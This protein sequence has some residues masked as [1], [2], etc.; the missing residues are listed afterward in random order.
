MPPQHQPPFTQREP[1]KKLIP[2]FIAGLQDFAYGE[3][4]WTIFKYWAPELISALIFYAFAIIDSYW[5]ADLKSTSTYTTLNVTNNFFHFMSKVAEGLSIGTVI[6]TGQYNGRSCLTDVGRTL[7]DSFWTTILVGG[8]FAAALSFGAHAIY[9]AYG[10]PQR[11]IEIGTP[12]LRLRAWG[13][14]FMFVSLAFIGFLRG[15]KNTRVP[16]WI[17]TGGGAFFV[18]FD[19]VLIKGKFGFPALG[20]KG[21]AIAS[22]AQYVAMS[23]MALGYTFLNKENKKYGIRLFDSFT[24][25]EDVKRLFMVSWP[26]ILDKATVAAAYIWLGAMVAKMGTLALASFSVIKDLERFAFLPAIAFAQVITFL[27]SN[28]YG[29]QDWRGIKS[30]IKKILFLSSGM[31]F[32]I[33]ALFS[34]YTDKLVP[35]FDRKGEFT[36][37]SARVFPYLSVLVFFDLLQL[38]LSGALRGAANVRVV[39]WT[40][41]FVCVLYFAP[42][43]YLFTQLPLD[44]RPALKF[45]L[46]YGSFYLGN[47]L[48]SIVYIRRFRGEAWKKEAVWQK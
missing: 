37:F 7:R 21:S 2:S 10:V 14:F 44:D 15:I 41:L 40:R 4:Y 30:S 22:V 5:I 13:I 18:L 29:M 31:T 6:I 8:I 48:M 33:L 9:T 23:I 1:Q 32:A 42:V 25:W 47:A 46:V 34:I 12:Y 45:F 26:T 39:M 28:S 20:L 16:M 3:T 38:I 27:V 35:L 19:Y 24:R 17:F 43:S 36:A 11:M